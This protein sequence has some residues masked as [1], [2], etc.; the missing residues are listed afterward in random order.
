MGRINKTN[1]SR[2]I[3][4][5]SGILGFASSGSIQTN[6]RNPVAGRTTQRNNIERFPH[7]LPTSMVGCIS[8]QHFE[9]LDV[10]GNKIHLISSVAMVASIPKIIPTI[11]TLISRF[12]AILKI[13]DIDD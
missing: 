11:A 8:F 2:A 10:N 5:I 6:D 12:I 13:G 9:Q 4:L 7:I 1:V 3:L